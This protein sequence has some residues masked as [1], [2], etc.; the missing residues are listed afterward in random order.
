VSAMSTITCGGCG[1][2]SRYGADAVVPDQL[3]GG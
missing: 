1:M 2:P 3:S